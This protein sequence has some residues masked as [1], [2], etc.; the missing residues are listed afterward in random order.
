MFFIPG[1]Q[2]NLRE[3][4]QKA[5]KGDLDAMETAVILIS[6]EGY[7]DD[8]P[9]GEIAERQVRYLRTL[10]ES[11]R[12]FAYIMLGGAYLKGEGTP[13]NAT[14]A[15]RWYEKA[16]ESGIHFGNE[17]IGMLY[18]EGR[19]IPCDYQKAYE[20]FT[21]DEEKSHSARPMHWGRCSG[22]D[23]T[24]RKMKRKPLSTTFRF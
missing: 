8:D 21:R 3:L 19:D 6:A 2:Y 10:A 13:Q 11:G 9:E 15:I 5:E 18:Y 23:F 14:E 4:L 7:T 16:A 22:R 20:Y 24:F 17:C 12:S 1:K